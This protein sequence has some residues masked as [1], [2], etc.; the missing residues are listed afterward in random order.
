MILVSHLSPKLNFIQSYIPFSKTRSQDE[1]EMNIKTYLFCS[2][3]TK[4]SQASQMFHAVEGGYF[5]TYL[6]VPTQYT[7]LFLITGYANHD[8]SH[9]STHWVSLV[10]YCLSLYK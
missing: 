3:V 8:V 7:V 10:G 5:S 6:L 9:F 1:I 2:V 4:Y